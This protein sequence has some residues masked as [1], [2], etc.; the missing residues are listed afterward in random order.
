MGCDRGWC[1]VGQCVSIC[2]VDRCDRDEIGYECARVE[3]N[4]RKRVNQTH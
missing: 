3:F 1:S 4:E 2:C